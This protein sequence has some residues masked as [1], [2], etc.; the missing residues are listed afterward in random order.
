MLFFIQ[1]F[2]VYTF[3]RRASQISRRHFV[4]C[5]RFQNRKKQKH[6][7]VWN[8]SWKSG[9]TV[10]M[11]FLT[12]SKGVSLGMKYSLR[13]K[14]LTR[15]MRSKYGKKN[16]CLVKTSAQDIRVSIFYASTKKKFPY[17]DFNVWVSKKSIF[18]HIL[19]K[20]YF[21]TFKILTYEKQCIY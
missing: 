3:V 5:T 13:I 11:G 21:S 7:F 1:K 12:F 20:D 15:S 19:P 10:V 18:R 16:R 4:K 6:C 9:L 8:N 17:L 14:Q 2:W